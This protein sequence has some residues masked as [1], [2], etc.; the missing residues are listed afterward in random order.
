MSWNERKVPS[1]LITFTWVIAF[2]VLKENNILNFI[3][4]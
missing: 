2:L 4:K 1:L 3:T